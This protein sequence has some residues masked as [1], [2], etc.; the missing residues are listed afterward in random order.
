M[1]QLKENPVFSGLEKLPPPLSPVSKTSGSNDAD[2]GL[3]GLKA[4]IRAKEAV[5]L[6]DDQVR[7]SEKFLELAVFVGF[8]AYRL[9]SETHHY[10][11]QQINFI[12]LGYV[13]QIQAVYYQPSL[14]G[15]L[16]ITVV[17]IDIHKSPQFETFQGDRDLLL[18]SFCKYQEKFNPQNDADPNHWDMALYLS[19]LNFY[20]AD[21]GET[22]KVTM[23][24]APVG[25][26]CYLNN[27][28]VI[29]EFGTV[30]DL[31]HP[32]PSSGLMSSWV[33]AHEMAHR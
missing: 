11:D 8:E 33:A 24:L 19:A 26:V 27:N 23:G 2:I 20:A 5:K 4:L 3:S 16:H 6:R 13:N 18:N 28:C 32:Y 30:N 1:N 29:A 21:Q 10:N 15:K 7:Y 9:L 25:G 14:G 12:V 31:H 17:R 22:N